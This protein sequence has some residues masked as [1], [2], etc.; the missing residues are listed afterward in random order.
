MKTNLE[1]ELETLSSNSF[2][3]RW[4]RF[5]GHTSEQRKS[6][7]AYAIILGLQK[8]ARIG[9]IFLAP[10]ALIIQIIFSL[11][12]KGCPVKIG[13]LNKKGRASIMISY[14]EPYL[15]KL[16]LEKANLQPLVIIINPGKDPSDQLSQMYGRVCW[17]IDERRPYLRQLFRTI[18]AILSLASSPM[19]VRLYS[20]LD[21]KFLKIWNEAEPS[22]NFSGREL[23]QGQTLLKE[24]GVPK[25]ADYVCLGLREDAY[26]QQFITPEYK[27]IHH[28]TAA[29]QEYRVRNPHLDNY[30]PAANRLAEKGTYV[31][32]MG[33][34]TDQ[35]LPADSNLKFIDYAN[36]GRTALGDIF[37][38][39]NCKFMISGGGAGMWWFASAFNR[40]VV[41]AD[42]YDLRVVP[43]R[44]GDLFIP[45]RYWVKKEKRFL[46]FREVLLGGAELA[47]EKVCQ[48]L[49]IE[50]VHNTPEEILAIIEEMEQRL[51]NTWN[52]NQEDEQLQE[53]F[54]ALYLPTYSGYGMP[55]RIGATFLRQNKELIF[56]S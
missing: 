55:G 4:R 38:F 26:Y 21:R 9:G 45:I 34:L 54:R 19:A 5:I 50:L 48:R 52:D 1:F 41:L 42:T 16:Q 56:N 14:I 3:T 11:V 40:P 37:L 32:R 29:L 36:R 43:L 51:S 6:V 53:K 15:R 28:N 27:K 24:L 2:A 23:E 44:S 10:M 35:K 47:N 7:L 13:T 31:L 18:Y 33:Q 46:T 17:L 25:G 30:L 8:I 12:Y 20:G 39:A 49:N 22:L